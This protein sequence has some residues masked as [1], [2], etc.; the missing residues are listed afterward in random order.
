MSAN[1]SNSS[2]LDVSDSNADSTN[3]MR[4][5]KFKSF[6]ASVNADSS[7]MATSG[8]TEFDSN[9]ITDS[10]LT[11]ISSTL[12]SSVFT[13]YETDKS[14]VVTKE[15]LQRKQLI[16]DMQVL[17]VE[18]SQRNLMIDS[19]KAES[20]NKIGDLEDRLSDAI[21]EKQLLVAKYESHLRI[22]RE[23]SNKQVKV[24]KLELQNYVDEV[25]RLKKENDS[26]GGRMTDIK[27]SYINLDLAEDEY[28]KLKGTS[29]ESLSLQDFFS[30]QAY[31]SI[32]PLKVQIETTQQ[33]LQLVTADLRDREDEIAQLKSDNDL[34]QHAK[35]ELDI[36][37]QRFQVQIEDLR[38]QL[39]H[40]SYKH[41]NFDAVQGERDVLERQICDLEKNCMVYK[42]ELQ[43]K[44]DE[45]DRLRNQFHEQN[46]TIALLKQDKE[47]LS[48]Q[49]NEMIPRCQVLD[50]RLEMTSRQL[51]EV[52]QSREDL[53]EKYIHARDHYKQEY[54]AR[55]KSEL[56]EITTRTSNELEKI[57]I[58]TKEMYDRENRNL[59]DSRD[60]AVLHQE[61]LALSEK[62]AQLKYN[63]LLGEFRQLQLSSDA[64]YSECSNEL[65]LKSFEVDRV[66]MLYEEALKNSKQTGI[67]YEAAQTKLQALQKE[68]YSLQGESD[69]KISELE[70]RNRETQSKL[71]IYEKLEQELDDVVMQAAEI[72]DEADAE[73]VLFAYGFG[74]NVPSNAKRR[75]QQSVHLARRVLQLERANTSLKH[76]LDQELK[77]NEQLSNEVKNSNSLLKEAQQPYNYLIESIQNR[78]GQNKSLKD[79]ITTLEDDIKRLKAE[80]KS[81]GQN[82]S[83]MTTD[84]ERLLNQREE[85][86]MLK[87]VVLKMDSSSHLGE[88]K[89]GVQ[90]NAASLPLSSGTIPSTVRYNVKSLVPER[91]FGLQKQPKPIMFTKSDQPPAWFLKL[92][93]Q[94]KVV[95]AKTDCK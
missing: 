54:E 33:R 40:K 91:D 22:N 85:M 20:M 84:L 49:V 60:A 69:K 61:K 43:G 5:Q 58:S 16:H 11:G 75:M 56:D 2:A 76:N 28:L 37:C 12:T 3:P 74:A 48:K 70:C 67:N 80:N 31:E 51:D 15:L 53:Y 79:T 68:F 66:Q 88:F 52:K 86:N 41:Q 6:D 36:R 87:Q 59:R 73:G 14:K 27:T 44:S 32:R 72:A 29:D 83:Q 8:Q 62:E 21:H 95:S 4:N 63:E 26:I 38:Q 77:K 92:K 13:D 90:Q 45:M 23:E 18:L 82:N 39:T 9:E 78:D 1:T 17:K 34:Q 25:S 55:V 89:N 94:N 50:E 64:K 46:Q 71:T 47:Y 10:S 81:L 24:L 57:K 19:I 42:N 35:T 65:K 7:S 30:I 93:Q